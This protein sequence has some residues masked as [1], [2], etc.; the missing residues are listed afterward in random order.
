MLAF[1]KMLLPKYLSRGELE[2]NQVL[3]SIIME[4]NSQTEMSAPQ[5]KNALK[6]NTEEKCPP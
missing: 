4:N 5:A 1:G 3:F 6:G 2:F